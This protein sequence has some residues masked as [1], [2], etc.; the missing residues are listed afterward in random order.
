[1][2]ASR[3]NVFREAHDEFLNALRPKDRD[4][5]AHCNS[6]DELV[7]FMKELDCVAAKGRSRRSNKALAFVQRL[8]ARLQ[9]YFDALNVIVGTEPCAA[10]SYGAFRIVLQLAAGMPVFFDKVIAILERLMDSFPQYDA[11]NPLFN[12]EPP[13]CLRRHLELVYKDL[14]Q[15][16][17]TLGRVLRGSNGQARSAGVQIISTLWDPFESKIGGVI[18]HMN[19]HRQF[20][21]DELQIIRLE[22]SQQAEKAVEREREFAEK[23]RLA[24]D[25]SRKQIEELSRNTEGVAWTLQEERRRMC[26][27]E[28]PSCQDHNT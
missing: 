11:I 3:S 27:I 8:Y 7:S 1:M 15:I 4:R 26:V 6:E 28:Q 19:E 13:P 17:L 12:G 14:F 25:A 20:I 10:L 21:K 23:E 18:S 9:P 16:L 22:Q 5:L 24:Q 2:S